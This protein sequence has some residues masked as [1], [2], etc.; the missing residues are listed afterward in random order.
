MPT[1]LHQDLVLLVC[2][3]LLGHV[4]PERLGKLLIA[5]FRIRLWEGKF[6]EPDIVPSPACGRGLR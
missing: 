3:L 2:G 6:R 5:P 4:Q 1:E